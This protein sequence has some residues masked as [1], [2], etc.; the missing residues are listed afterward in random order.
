MSLTSTLL[1]NYFSRNLF[2]IQSRQLNLQEYQSKELLRSNGC[3]V[4]NFFVCEKEEKDLDKLFDK[5]DYK[6]YVVKAQILAGG[7]GKGRFINSQF[8]QSGVFIT[9]S[10]EQAKFSTLDMLGRRL[11]TNQ[12]GSDG[13][14]V[15]Q[16]MIAES[17]PIK[18]EAYLSILMDPSTSGPVVVACHM[19]GVDIEKVA[20]RNPELILKLPICINKGITKEQCEQVAEW[21]C[22]DNEAVPYN[23]LIKLLSYLFLTYFSF[24]N[25]F[26]IYI[27]LFS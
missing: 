15:N 9:T 5:Y 19:G 16:V 26:F 18:R 6:E 2:K 13:V 17:V 7:R 11:V 4:Q 24:L 8:K 3:V 14:L 10:Q 25:L 23:Y 1:K 21:L 27:L 12:T 22:F 20:E